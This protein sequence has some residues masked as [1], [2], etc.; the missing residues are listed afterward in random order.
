MGVASSGIPATGV[1]SPAT[2]VAQL[3][4]WAL[5]T[6]VK[7]GFHK[8]G[9][10]PGWFRLGNPTQWMICGHFRRKFRSQTSDNMDRWKGTARK[11]LREVESQKIDR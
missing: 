6:L 7:W 5:T 1:L 2:S 4:D 9:S 10:Q 3:D 11:K 8:W